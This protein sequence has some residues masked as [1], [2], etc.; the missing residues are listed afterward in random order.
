MV[1][2]SKWVELVNSIHARKLRYGMTD[3]DEVNYEE[4]FTL[5]FLDG[6]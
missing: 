3:C 2:I 5:W 1:I 4:S 6:R